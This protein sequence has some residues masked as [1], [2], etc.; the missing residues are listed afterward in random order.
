MGEKLCAVLIYISLVLAVSG[1]L[2]S[3]PNCPVYTCKSVNQTFTNITCVYYTKSATTSTYYVNPCTSLKAP[4][5]TPSVMANSTCEPTPSTPPLNAW[6]GEKCTKNSD[7]NSL[8]AR[9]GCVGG[10]CVGS[11]LNEI[12]YTNDDCNPGLRCFNEI[13]QPQIPIG[14]SQCTSDYDCV[15]GAGCNVANT[16]INSVCYPYFSIASHLPVGDCT[17]DNI[18]YLCNSGYCMNNNGVYECMNTLSSK[19]F[20]NICQVDGD[21]YSTRDDFF[22]SGVLWGT[23]YCGYNP[24]ATSYCS[25]YFGDKP[26]VQAITYLKKW[27]QSTNINSCN[28]MRRFNTECISDWWDAKDYSA[29]NYYTLNAYFWPLIEGS[30]NC[31]QQVYLPNWYAAK[32]NMS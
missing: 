25:L 23:C 19:T 7:C 27:I 21:C 28:T 30:D 31:T 9:G 17:S 15:N 5:C 14:Q 29:Y 1:A 6:P 24:T 22:P 4:Y 18:S 26:Y 2:P 10:T 3:N 8:H 32:K 12:C 13:C 11:A 16:P 20:P